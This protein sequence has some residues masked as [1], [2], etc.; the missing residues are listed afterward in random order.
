[1]KALFLIFHGFDKA[2]GIS[3]KIHYQVK[4]LKECGV[5]VRLCYYDITANG[6]RRWMV[7]DEVIADFGTG[8]TA[9]IWKRIYYKAITE[10]ARREEIDLVYIR[11]FHNANPFTL[12]MVNRLNRNGAK[13]VMEIPTYPYDQEYISR[14]MKLELA[15]DRCFRHQLA[16]KL[17]GIVTF[18]NAESIFGGRT[19]RISNGIDFDAIPLKSNRNDT[20]HELHLIGVAEVHYWHGFDRIVKGLAEY[21]RTNPEYKV[22]FHIIGPLAGEREREDILPA[23]R[24]NHL[25]PYVILHGPLHGDELDA[26]FEKADFAIGSL[27][28]HRSGITYIKTLKNREYAARGI[29]FTYSE[30]DEDF[31]AMPYVWKV[32]ADESP[33]DI[34][35][36]IVFFRA[37]KMM[38][39][40]IR[41]SVRPLSWKAQMQKV[42][43][44]INKKMTIA[45]CIPS[46]YY[47][48]G[49]ERVL[50]LKA[51][52]FVEHFGYDVHIILTDGKDKKPYY[53]L[54]P[55]ITLHQLD[56]NYDELYGLSLPKRIIGYWNRQRLFKKRLND[57]LCDIRPDITISLLRRDINFINNMKDGSVKLGEIHFNKSNY[58]E[59]SDNRLPHFL[60]KMVRQFWMRQL[61]RQLRR[62]KYFIVLSHEDAAEW[63]ELSNV[64]VIYNPLPFFPDRQSDNTQKQV[65]AV[66]RYMPQKGFDRLIPAWSIVSKKH[67]DWTLSIYGDGMREKLQQQIDELGISASCLLKHSVQNIVEKYC[68][69]SIFV[70]SSRFEGFGMV[71]IEAMSCGVPPV[72]FTCPC[73]PRDII[74]DG[75]D[76]LLVENGDIEGLAEKICYLI[77]NEDVRKKMGS[78]ARVNVERFKIEHIAQQWKELFESALQDNKEL[79]ET[80]N[81]VFG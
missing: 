26:Q 67:P 21:Y 1:M 79:I 44:T 73:G 17:D 25:E 18:S 61:I 53:E 78:L 29:A 14:S 48:S 66:G 60:Q 49:M 22:Y 75:K 57:C 74:D 5:D 27:G 80:E 16:K 40:E 42:V 35:K 39:E 24:D 2:N 11:S 19:I 72:S 8:V 41:E 70:L 30:T 69:N 62:M 46:L 37:Q 15:I 76:G 34:K 64:K 7:D 55:S 38:P 58:R 54:H 36:L 20:S 4:A 59:F 51:N 12:R 63:T 45:Y 56:L 9:K 13:V 23:I 31:D 47:P 28:R 50:T 32:A 6:D 43:E 65:I 68:E 3:K 71:I 77:E 52:Y 81:R 10:Y 33:I